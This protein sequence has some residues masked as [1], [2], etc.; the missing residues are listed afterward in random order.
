VEAGDVLA[1]AGSTGW[2]ESVRLYFEVRD[3][4]RPVNPARWCRK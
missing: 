2:V 1:D 3:R 4:G